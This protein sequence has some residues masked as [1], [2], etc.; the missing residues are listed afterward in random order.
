MNGTAN[1]DAETIRNFWR[2][3][4]FFGSGPEVLIANYWYLLFLIPLPVMLVWGFWVDKYDSTPHSLQSVTTVLW[5]PYLLSLEIALFLS[6]IAF[7]YWQSGMRDTFS[8]A[9]DT[10]L[11]FCGAF[12]MP[13][14]SCT[15][16]KIS[17]DFEQ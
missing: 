5:D 14:I 10:G 4:P 7:Q 2:R 15:F 8:T 17:K 6:G 9:V 11:I 1:R 16:A 13:I 12:G 3:V